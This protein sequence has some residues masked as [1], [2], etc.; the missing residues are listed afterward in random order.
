MMMGTLGVHPMPMLLHRAEESRFGSPTEELKLSKCCQLK[1]SKRKQLVL[2][3]SRLGR[4][5]CKSLKTAGDKFPARRR[6]KPASLIDVASGSLPK[7]PVS[8][9]PGDEVPHMFTR[10]PRL[11]ARKICDQQ[12]KKTFATQSANTRHVLTA[13]S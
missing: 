13:F 10:N 3:T 7:S 2:F 12:C 1:P 11:T 8:L 9:S 4:L 5:C 6:N